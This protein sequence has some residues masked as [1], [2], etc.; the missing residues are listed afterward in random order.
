MEEARAFKNVFRQVR[1]S[2]LIPLI[3][4]VVINLELTLNTQLLALLAKDDVRVQDTPNKLNGGPSTQTLLFSACV[5]EAASIAIVAS[6]LKEM[7]ANRPS[8]KATD[9]F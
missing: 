2:D 3:R 7:S 4:G 9:P 6:P 8:S 5:A 1:G